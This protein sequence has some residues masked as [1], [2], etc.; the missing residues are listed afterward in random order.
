MG[1]DENQ[2]AFFK[3]AEDHFRFQTTVD[4]WRGETG[5]RYDLDATDWH[6]Y[7]LSVTGTSC[8]LYVDG[9]A[10][11]EVS[12]LNTS[13]ADMGSSQ[14]FL[15]G[16][17]FYK[18]DVGYSGYLDNVA[19]YR[20]ALT[21]EEIRAL[22]NPAQQLQGD[23]NADGSVNTADAVAMTKFLSANGTLAD[24]EAGDLDGDSRITAKYLTLLKRILLR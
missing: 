8:T 12:D 5:M 10:V 15:L 17:S 21:A 2:Y 4:T 19:V 18:D 7:A 14:K 20:T 11:A 23:V 1:Q 16:K 3:I 9:T 6:S 24:W 22:H 13:P